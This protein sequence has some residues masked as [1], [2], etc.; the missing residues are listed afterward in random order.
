MSKECS[1]PLHGPR[2]PGIVRYGIT[3]LSWSCLLVA[4]VSRI[5]YNLFTITIYSRTISNCRGDH[6][7]IFKPPIALDLLAIGDFMCISVENCTILSV[8]LHEMVLAFF[9][10]EE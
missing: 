10:T 6:R 7:G 1:F 5:V 8:V 3:R 2:C 4:I 9:C